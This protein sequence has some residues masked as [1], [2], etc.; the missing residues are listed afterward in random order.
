MLVS[1]RPCWPLPTQTLPAAQTLLRTP[2]PKSIVWARVSFPAPPVP[3]QESR[4][5]GQ[6]S[7]GGPT[8]VGAAAL[9]EE[10]GK[11]CTKSPSPEGPP[12]C[13]LEPLLRA[14]RSLAHIPLSGGQASPEP[15]QPWGPAPPLPPEAAPSHSRGAHIPLLQ[16]SPEP[17]AQLLGSLNA[18]PHQDPLSSVLLN[19]QVF[20]PAGPLP[21]APSL[22]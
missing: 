11:A 1:G 16:G 22:P 2:H 20:A 19:P 12:L 15:T 13:F 9:R 7:R 8:P 10:G 17:R 3:P 6:V 4:K 5:P 18:H 21:R 14:G